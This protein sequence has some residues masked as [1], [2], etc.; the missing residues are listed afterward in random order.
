M[1]AIGVLAGGF[2][3]D[4]TRRHG[5]VAAGAYALTAA[6]VAH[7]A[8]VAAVPVRPISRL[9]PRATMNSCSSG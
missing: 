3:A 2:V 5:E 8:P 1:S 4:R 7:S 6:L 9:T